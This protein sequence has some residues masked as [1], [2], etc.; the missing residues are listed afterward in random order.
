[1]GSNEGRLRGA[2]KGHG[3]DVGS[4]EMK[5]CRH[6]KQEDGIGNQGRMIKETEGR[7]REAGE[8]KREDKGGKKME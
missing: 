1:M 5:L 6:G 2:M 4:I 3:G 7:M 8:E